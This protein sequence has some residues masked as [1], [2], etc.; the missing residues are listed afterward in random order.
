MHLFLALP[1]CFAVVT[2]FYALGAELSLT[3]WEL[4]S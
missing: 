2:A 4:S 1:V 3:L